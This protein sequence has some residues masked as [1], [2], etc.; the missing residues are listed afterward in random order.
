[1]KNEIIVYQNKEDSTRLEVRIED[2]TVWLSQTQMAELFQTT[3]QNIIM[4]VGNIYRE[5]ELNYFRL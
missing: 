2:E 5:K 1:M 4:H 3:A